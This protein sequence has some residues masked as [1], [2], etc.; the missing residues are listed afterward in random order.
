MRTF[1]QATIA[2]G[3]LFL[4]P[5]VLTVLL[6]REMLQ[7]AGKLFVPMARLLPAEHVAGVTA[8][9][10]LTVVIIVAVCF[11]AGLLAQTRIGRALGDRL[12]RV[13]LGRVP[14][15]TFLK[16]MTRDLVG[17]GMGTDRRCA[18]QDRRGLGA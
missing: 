17:L 1:M 3:F 7:V 2:G 13:V 18:S 9:D 15:F 16:S 4:V 11:V 6:L 5:L 8:V 14:G 12:E 10:L